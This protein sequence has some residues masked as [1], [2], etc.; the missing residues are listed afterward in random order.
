M[1][2]PI[3]IEY[4]E[5]DSSFFGLKIGRISGLS[6]VN[7]LPCLK[8]LLL[9]ARQYNFK[10]IYLVSEVDISFEPL[11]LKMDQAILV[12]KKVIYEG[13]T[14]SNSYNYFNVEEYQNLNSTS[15]LDK[16]ACLAGEYSR[17]RY[18]SR[19]K[20]S[21]Y[22]RIYKEWIKN[23][24]RKSIADKVYVITRQKEIIAMLTIKKNSDHGTIGLIAVGIDHQGKGYG[25]Q[26]I[27]AAKKYLHDHGVMNIQ[28]A[29]QLSNKGACMFYES[30][31][32]TVKSI[33]NIYHIWL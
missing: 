7:E 9:H 10:L 26:L 25:K 5:W 4:L 29:T 23:S 13:Y 20:D 12:D 11:M 33:N 31:G 3:K 24:V 14:K 8:D 19:F 15:D 28:V 22:K 1:N 16:L 2:K 32:F 18:D 17:F 21:D 6:N 30:C 27:E